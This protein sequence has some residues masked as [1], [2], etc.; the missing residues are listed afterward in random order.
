M[1]G[2]QLFVPCSILDRGKLSITHF[3]CRR[4]Q[5]YGIHF[6]RRVR[7]QNNHFAHV[8]ENPREECDADFHGCRNIEG[9]CGNVG[10]HHLLAELINDVVDQLGPAAKRHL[11]LLPSV[12]PRDGIRIILDIVV[13]RRRDG[14]L[15]QN[16]R[17]AHPVDAHGNHF[18]PFIGL[19]DHVIVV[20]LPDGVIG[21]NHIDFS[22]MPLNLAFVRVEVVHLEGNLLFLLDALGDLFN[23]IEDFVVL[24]LQMFGDNDLRGEGVLVLPSCE[25]GQLFDSCR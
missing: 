24:G 6:P 10:N 18:V 20:L 11:F 13:W 22:A 8:L 9:F 5:H 23:D 4:L 19:A 17:Q 2:R 15:V 16:F 1:G 12:H 7:R 14:I 21:R 25:D 3:T